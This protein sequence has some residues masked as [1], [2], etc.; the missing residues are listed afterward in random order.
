VEPVPDDT[1]LHDGGGD[2]QV[3][4]TTHPMRG[5]SVLVADAT[6]GIDVVRADE[7]HRRYAVLTLASTRFLT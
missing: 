2:G 7:L 6:G 5:A 1:P 4:A 3:S